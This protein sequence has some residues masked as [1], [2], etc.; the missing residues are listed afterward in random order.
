MRRAAKVDENQA[1]IVAALRAAGASVQSLAA[2]GDGCPDLLVGYD[3]GRLGLRLNHLLEVK[4]L[5]SSRKDKLN[6]R[7]ALWHAKWRG[8]VHVVRNPREALQVIGVPA[9]E[10]DKIAAG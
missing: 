6:D 9:R 2:V 10:V 4:D 5:A 3:S 1:A 8:G 7:Q